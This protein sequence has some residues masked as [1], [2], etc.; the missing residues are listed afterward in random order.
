MAYT[1]YQYTTSPRKVETEYDRPK[2]KKAKKQKLKIVDNVQRQ[3]IRVSK[4]QRIKQQEQ[5]KNSMKKIDKLKKVLEKYNISY[6][7]KNVDTGHF[8]TRRKFDN[9]LI[10][11]Y[12]W[13]GK[14]SKL[15]KIQKARG[16]KALLQI[17][18]G[19]E[20]L[21]NENTSK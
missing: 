20:V 7:L 2:K 12:I 8:H 6:E 13:T 15:G 14:I 5:Q 19:K 16:E 21:T 4:E 18:L 10:E 1:K 9:Q 17:L 11:Y 3:D